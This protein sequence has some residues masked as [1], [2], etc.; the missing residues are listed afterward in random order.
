M[1]V[2]GGAAPWV[3]DPAVGF[4]EAEVGGSG[5]GSQPDGTMFLRRVFLAGTGRGFEVWTAGFAASGDLFFCEVCCCG[6]G[7]L[8][9]AGAAVD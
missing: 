1:V 2:E 8:S 9:E 3:A 4:V 6:A 7:L 5:A